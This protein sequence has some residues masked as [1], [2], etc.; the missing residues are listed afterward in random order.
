MDARTASETAVARNPV[1]VERT[2]DR[3]IVVTRVFNSPARLVFEAWTTPELFQQWW[4][5]KSLGMTLRS[6]EMDARTGGSYRLDFGDGADFFGTYLEVTP[7]TRIVWTNDDGGGD[8]SVTTVSFEER[9]NT[10]LLVMREVWPSAEAL[11][12]G[13]GAEQAT[14]E[15]FGQLDELLAQMQV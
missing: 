13:A 8:S 2:S 7:H 11:E 9:G 14:H 1:T 12:A 6:L 10:T 15:T 5:P 4:V 3:E